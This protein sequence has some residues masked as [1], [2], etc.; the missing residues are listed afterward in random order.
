MVACRTV[1][2]FEVVGRWCRPLLSME[3]QKVSLLGFAAL[4][5]TS[6]R[7]WNIEHR[8]R[9]DERRARRWSDSLGAGETKYVSPL[10]DPG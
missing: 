9:S 1:L 2:D 7:D 3:W 4:R 8:E 6:I 5:T 10:E